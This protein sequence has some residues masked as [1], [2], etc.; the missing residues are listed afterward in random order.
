MSDCGSADVSSAA[1]ENSRRD[2]GAPI[3]KSWYSRGYLPH[4]DTPGLVQSITF[5]LNDSLPVHVLH[6]LAQEND[7]DLEKLKQIETFLD[8]GHGECW[9]KQPDIASIV[10]DALLHGDGQHYRLLAWCV[11]PNHVHVLIEILEGYRLSK[12]VQG[13]KSF[14]A[15]LINQ[16]LGRTGT[17]WMREYF[18]RYIRDDHHLAA[19]IAYIHSNPV[20]AG[21][22][23]N[24]QDWLHSSAS[25]R[26]YGSAVFGSAD[27][28]S[29]TIQKTADEDVGAPIQI[30]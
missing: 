10:E 11:M 17:V 8:A 27:V 23:S 29:A 1:V 24:E 26:V 3:N 6:R 9:L 22:V 19:V 5:R 20:K 21:L 25:L 7:D 14:T 12:V 2:V 4:C 30:R 28:S 13:W 15:K 16:H 18:D